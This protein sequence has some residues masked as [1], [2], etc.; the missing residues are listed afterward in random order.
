MSDKNNQFPQYRKLPNGKSL[1]R[2]DSER[3][4]IELHKMGSRWWLYNVEA[5]QYP[6]MLRIIDML[7]LNDPFIEATALEFEVIHE[8]V[9]K[10]VEN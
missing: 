2:I 9:K 1:Y 8:H 7:E 3:L 10:N 5:K 4:F 6:E